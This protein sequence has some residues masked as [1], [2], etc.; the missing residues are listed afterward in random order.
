M[1]SLSQDHIEKGGGL[2]QYLRDVFSGKKTLKKKLFAKPSDSRRNPATENNIKGKKIFLPVKSTN[3]GA[4]RNTKNF[5]TT[6]KNN[7]SKLSLY[8]RLKRKLKPEE[9]VESNNKLLKNVL[10]ERNTTSTGNLPEGLYDE[11]INAQPLDKL[12][13]TSYPIKKNTRL[14]FPLEIAKTPDDELPDPGPVPRFT[15]ARKLEK[16]NER[17]RRGFPPDIEPESQVEAQVRI[18]PFIYALWKKWVTPEFFLD[19]EMTYPKV[20]ETFKRNNWPLHMYNID[21]DDLA[22]LC[23]EV[24]SYSLRESANAVFGT[25]L[26]SMTNIVK[27]LEYANKE[28]EQKTV[29]QTVEREFNGDLT[30]VEKIAILGSGSYDRYYGFLDLLPTQIYLDY[31]EDSHR[32]WVNEG[33]EIKRNER[34]RK[35]D[36]KFQPLGT[37]KSNQC[38]A[39]IPDLYT[40]LQLVLMHPNSSYLAGNWIVFNQNYYPLIQ[41]GGPELIVAKSL[42]HASYFQ[43]SLDDWSL[44]GM[45]SELYKLFMI[46]YPEYAMKVSTYMTIP[47]RLPRLIEV[48][49]R[50]R[51]EYPV[52]RGKFEYV[53]FILIDEEI[54]GEETTF[55][56]H[57]NPFKGEGRIQTLMKKGLNKKQV[58]GMSPYMAYFIKR[59]DPSLWSLFI[60]ESYFGRETSRYLK[61]YN[62][63]NAQQ[64]IVIDYLQYIR[65]M[66][67][68]EDNDNDFRLAKKSYKDNLGKKDIQNQMFRILEEDRNHHRELLRFLQ[69]MV[70]LQMPEELRD[71][72]Y[73]SN[74]Q[75]SNILSSFGSVDKKSNIKSSALVLLSVEER[76]LNIQI[77]SRLEAKKAEL[78]NYLKNAIVVNKRNGTLKNKNEML[79]GYNDILRV[80]GLKNKTRSNYKQLKNLAEAQFKQI[81]ALRQEILELQSKLNRYPALPRS[82]NSN[83]PGGFPALPRSDNSNN[84]RSVGSNVSANVR[85]PTFNTMP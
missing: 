22:L 66:D 77:Q 75:I 72:V 34:G 47:E 20:V 4:F 1:S 12:G 57:V 18:L 7:R 19:P 25:D 69:K 45:D 62:T 36:E 41:Q 85:I 16:Q 14:E 2:F 58:Y 71:Q 61:I 40:F 59:M 35:L 52:G 21:K 11:Y 81:N 74:T 44:E 31:E 8:T 51:S 28:H 84:E 29:I 13:I 60:G 33:A 24:S 68:L 10:A 82:A 50:E 49:K 15:E 17:R 54:L 70:N 79:R 42:A 43:R 6:K 53:N 23:N 80:P 48:I 27:D 30:P 55:M 73:L 39:I 46:K 3:T 83:R 56:C 67:I 64:K 5:R 26:K 63:L 38:I 76:P 37:L 32:C 65:F 9:E 78:R